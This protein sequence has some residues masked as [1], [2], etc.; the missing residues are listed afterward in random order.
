MSKTSHK[1]QCNGKQSTLCSCKDV[2]TFN[3]KEAEL[4]AMH[5]GKKSSTSDLF[6]IPTMTHYS[7]L[8]I[9]STTPVPSAKGNTTMTLPTR[10]KRSDFLVLYLFH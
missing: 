4:K 3:N 8:S 6:W 1:L 2:S 10:Y 5:V 9:L 7:S